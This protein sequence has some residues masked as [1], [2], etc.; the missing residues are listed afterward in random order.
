MMNVRAFKILDMH[1][2]KWQFGGTPK[3]GCANGLFTLKTLL[4]MRKNHNLQTHVCFVKAYD[5]A[6]HKLN[7][8]LLLFE[9]VPE[10]TIDQNQGSM[11]DWV[12]EVNNGKYWKSLIRCLLKPTE[13]I[14]TRPTDEGWNQTP[15]PQPQPAP[16][17]T[18]EQRRQ[19]RQR[20]S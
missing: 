7:C 14:P 17:P 13:E 19:L 18:P 10:V 1:G 2:T 4:N 11:I 9:R 20:S 12:K 8:L 16:C 6:D 5:T 3:Q 15:R